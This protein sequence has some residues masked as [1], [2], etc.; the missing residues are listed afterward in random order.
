MRVLQRP[1]I[2]VLARPEVIVWVLL[3]VALALIDWPLDLTNDW[4]AEHQIFVT[5]GTSVVLLFAGAF[6]F[7]AWI[8]RREAQQ[9]RRVATVAYR[10]LSQEAKDTRV[11]LRLFVDGTDPALEGAVVDASKVKRFKDLLSDVEGVEVASPEHIQRLA[12]REEWLECVL[13]SLR[14]AKRDGWKC[15]TD[16]APVM[17]SVGEL[18]AD[19]DAL[20]ILN[21]RV[22]ALQRSVANAL[23]RRRSGESADGSDVLA[24][25]QDVI[26]QSFILEQRLRIEAGY[27][28]RN[29]PMEETARFWG[30]S[31]DQLDLRVST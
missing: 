27:A 9:W 5:V 24:A 16:W 25:I 8:Q 3:L 22:I 29:R 31:L 14:D 15:V 7:N 20:A 26:R 21:D 10:A 18:A 12:C 6:A 19:L 1:N 13:A 17:L 4:A 11:K 28:R 30:V 23:E 2:A